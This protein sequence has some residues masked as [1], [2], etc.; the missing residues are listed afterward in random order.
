M[1]AG[2]LVLEIRETGDA[3]LAEEELA[4]ARNPLVEHHLA[5]AGGIG[6][7]PVNGGLDRLSDLELDLVVGIQAI[8]QG[9]LC[10]RRWPT[11]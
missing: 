9:Y 8:Q 1:A 10:F 11:S 5:A 3:V 4:A 6:I 2:L 7:H